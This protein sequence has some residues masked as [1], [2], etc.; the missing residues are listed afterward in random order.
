M[1]THLYMMLHDL[2]MR[3]MPARMAAA[4]Y[5][6]MTR[7]LRPSV[8]MCWRP[9]VPAP[10]FC[11]LSL[12]AELGPFPILRKL[13]PPRNSNQFRLGHAGPSERS[14]GLRVPSIHALACV[15]AYSWL[16]SSTCYH[17]RE[18]GKAQDDEAP[19]RLNRVAGL[20]AEPRLAASK[21]ESR[22]AERTSR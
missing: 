16:R 9:L 6:S 18:Y 11:P 17:M 15:R 5:V 21:R 22:T 1:T 12:L 20:S 10:L 13:Q 19:A 4:L 7:G 8:S 3:T 14:V 2:H